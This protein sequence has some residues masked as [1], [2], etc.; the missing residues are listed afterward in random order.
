MSNDIE[1][2]SGV[3]QGSHLEPLLFLI[4]INDVSSNFLFSK[5]LLLADDLKIFA[6]VKTFDDR[7]KL[8]N[9]LIR[10]S[11]WCKENGVEIIC[12]FF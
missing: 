11:N 8:Q 1:V 12:V 5:Y 2:K 9:D 6:K 7:V 4:Y 3:N 10:F